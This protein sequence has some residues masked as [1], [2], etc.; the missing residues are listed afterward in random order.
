MSKELHSKL[1]HAVTFGAMGLIST[2]FLSVAREGLETSLFLYASFKTLGETAAPLIGL[3]TGLLAAIVLGILVYRR[4]IKINLSKF[5]TYTGVG[6]ILIAASVLHMGIV[7]VAEFVGVGISDF[8]AWALV[9][10]YA[11]TALKFYLTPKSS[12]KASTK[13]APIAHA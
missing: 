1:D 10:I 5:F 11:L 3:V 9:A 8:V 12:T 7:D 6:L 13:P 2:A 4:S